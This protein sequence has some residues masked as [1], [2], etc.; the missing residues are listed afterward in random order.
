MTIPASPENLVGF[1]LGDLVRISKGNVIN[2]GSP[3]LKDAEDHEKISLDDT[4]VG[5]ICV[6]YK[7]SEGL[8]CFVTFTKFASRPKEDKEFTVILAESVMEVTCRFQVGDTVRVKP[9]FTSREKY[10]SHM[11]YSYTQEED[12]EA[13][14]VAGLEGNVI[15]VGG[16]IEVDFSFHKKEASSTEMAIPLYAHLPGIFLERLERKDT[17]VDLDSERDVHEFFVAYEKEEAED[18][19]AAEKSSEAEI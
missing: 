16:D 4:Y 9:C 5:Y 10:S 14:V 15:A 19:L 13:V 2:E 1:Q 3:E 7:G 18:Q 12:A 11:S 17:Y 8:D 6:D